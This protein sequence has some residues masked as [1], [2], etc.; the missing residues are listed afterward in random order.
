MFIAYDIDGNRIVAQKDLPKDKQ[1]FCPICNAQLK[2]KWA[3]EY[4]VMAPHFAHEN[5]D[6]CKDTFTHDMSAWH[7]DWQELFPIKN[8]EVVLTH[9]GETHRADVMCYG[10]VIEFQHSPISASEFRERNRFYTSAGKKVVWIF[11]MT[12]LY[13][14]SDESGRLYVSRCFHKGERCIDEFRWK[15]PLKV[16][17]GFWPQADANVEIFFHIT[18]WGEDA[19]SKEA[20]AYMEKV[21]WVDP[22]HKP[23]WGVFRTSYEIGNYYD[24]M[25]LLYQQWMRGQNHQIA[26]KNLQCNYKYQVDGEIVDASEFDE[27]LKQNQPYRK[28]KAGCKNMFFSGFGNPDNSESWCTDP[29]QK[30]KIDA[31]GCIY[32]CYS[33][34]AV[35]QINDSESYIYCK[36]PYAKGLK[37]NAKIF[38]RI[39]TN[40]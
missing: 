27:F 32:G 18:P 36:S 17:E 31:Q 30:P 14:G 21:I 12:S 15:N 4:G 39:Y 16:L 6:A 28:I 11:D 2:Y 33:C 38:K 7:K 37:F 24:L 8:R 40:L 10:T 26:R 35:E 3:G 29:H 23:L 9:D 25:N 13:S 1:Y 34:V 19:K 20:E 22:E 5:G